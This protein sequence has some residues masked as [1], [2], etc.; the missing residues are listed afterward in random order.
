MRTPSWLHLALSALVL[1]AATPSARADFA[2]GAAA[3]GAG[4]YAAAMREWAPLAELGD[5]RAQFALGALYEAGR[6]VPAV[7][8]QQAVTW[9]QAAAAQGLPAA[10]NNLAILYAAGRGVSLSPF[11]AA[12]LWHKAAAAGHPPAQFNLALAYERGFGLP[13]DFESAAR[14]YAEA[15]NHGLADA[16]FAISE[17]YRTGRGSVPQHD[18]LAALWLDVARKFGSPLKLRQDFLAAAPGGK[19]DAAP[20]VAAAAAPA[21]TAPAEAAAAPEAAAPAEAV[22]APAATPAAAAP[23]A[24]PAAEQPATAAPAVDPAGRFA[25]QLA[26]LASEAEASQIGT[27]I[28]AKHPDLLGTFDLLVRRADLGAEKGVWYRV[29]AGPFAARNT[30]DDLCARLRAAPK[31][32]DCLVVKLK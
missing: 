5:A 20:P 30:A 15:G 3:Y 7:D 1:A 11:S 16:A 28:K 2:A 8:L 6:G 26:S 14:W 18:E 12:D 24:A 29:L 25:V 32:A 19:G 9:Y 4:N 21:A 10:Q 31:P 22:A 23:A 27:I 13:R 17:F